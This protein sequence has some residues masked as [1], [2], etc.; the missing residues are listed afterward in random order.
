VSDFAL[1]YQAALNGL[2][3]ALLPLRVAWAGL[4][5]ESLVRVAKEWNTPEKDIHVVYP[6]RRGMLPS[7]RTLVDWLVQ[8][9]PTALAE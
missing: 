9:V 7:V 1:Q 3:V 4:R 6:S 8:R 2:G 5:D